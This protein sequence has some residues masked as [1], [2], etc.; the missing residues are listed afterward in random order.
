[1]PRDS[2][3]LP[4]IGRESIDPESFWQTAQSSRGRHRRSGLGRSGRGIRHASHHRGTTKQ[5]AGVRSRWRRDNPF[6]IGLG[7]LSRTL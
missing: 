4:D 5:L 7:P 6:T 2:P 3:E 1:L